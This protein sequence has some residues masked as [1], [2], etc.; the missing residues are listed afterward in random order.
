[1]NP[2][3]NTATSVSLSTAAVIVVNYILSLFHL[4]PMPTDVSESVGLLLTAGAGYYL[5]RRTGDPTL[6][7][8]LTKPRTPPAPQTPQGA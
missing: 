6:G 8:F 4:A 3:A 7:L 2:A 1:M 5:H